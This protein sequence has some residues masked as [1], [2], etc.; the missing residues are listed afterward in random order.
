MFCNRQLNASTQVTLLRIF[1]TVSLQKINENNLN[2]RDDYGVAFSDQQY[3]HGSYYISLFK[4]KSFD[5]S[6][7]PPPQITSNFRHL[8]SCGTIMMVALSTALS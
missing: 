3:R 7:P 6:D 2:E 1:L 5:Q 4:Y 8:L